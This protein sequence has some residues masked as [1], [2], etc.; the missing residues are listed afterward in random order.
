M[1]RDKCEYG[2]HRNPRRASVCVI[3]DRTHGYGSGAIDI[4]HMHLCGT[5]AN[6]RHRDYDKGDKWTERT[7][8]ECE[9]S[10]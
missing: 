5:H 8:Q 10:Q 1:I 4:K 2:Q 7:L 9:A 3:W 6:V